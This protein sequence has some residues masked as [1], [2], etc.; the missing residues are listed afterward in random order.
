MLLKDESENA[1]L[2]SR[3]FLEDVRKKFPSTSDEDDKNVEN[4]ENRVKSEALERF[5]RDKKVILNK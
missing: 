1:H 5:S 2:Y 4:I 3:R